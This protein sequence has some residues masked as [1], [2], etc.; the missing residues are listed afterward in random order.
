[1]G[2]RRKYIRQVVNQLLDEHGEMKAAVNVERIAEAMGAIISRTVVEDELSGFI[3]RPGP[4]TAIIGVNQ[5]HHENRQ[6]FTIAHELGHMLLHAGDAVRWDRRLQFRR[7]PDDP[8]EDPED[9][10]VEANYFA[11]ELLMPARFLEKDLLNYE[12]GD[13]MDNKFEKDVLVPLARDYKV[14]K[15]A[16]TIRLKD[17]GYIEM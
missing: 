13:F 16:M 9:E 15:Q 5:S 3:Y 7:E 1:M 17:L 10:E 6:R 11:A 14:S 8:D 4:S 2:V 12:F